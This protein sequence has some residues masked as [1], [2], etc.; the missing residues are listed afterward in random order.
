MKKHIKP[1]KFLQ[2]LIVVFGRF[3][4]FP[5]ELLPKITFCAIEP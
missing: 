5:T 1:S 3:I 2:Q 4:I